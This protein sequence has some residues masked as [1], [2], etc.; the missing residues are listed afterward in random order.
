MQNAG[1]IYDPSPAD[2]RFQLE[3]LV[4]RW[5]LVA[6]YAL[7][8]QLGVIEV[9]PFWFFV[10]EGFLVTWH[11]YYT[12]YVWHE[13]TQE[14]LNAAVGYAIPFLDTV[15]VTL[16]LIAIGEPMHPIWAVY[17]FIM[18]SVA[19]FY[20]P[21]ARQYAVW[22]AV[23]YALVGLMT[24]LRGLPVP[25]AHMLVAGVILLAGLQNLAAYTGG[26]RRLRSQMSEIARIDPLTSLRNRRGLEEALDG[27]LKSASPG[28]GLALLMLDVDHFKRYNDQ[29]GHLV[30]DDILEQLGRLLVSSGRDIDIVAR[31]GG[32]EF[33]IALPDVTATDAVSIAE[34]LRQRVERSA[35]CTISIGVGVAR[36]PDTDIEELLNRADAALRVAKEAGRNRVGGPTLG[37][38]AA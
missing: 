11:V 26:E 30:A 23:N 35:L 9:T 21:V 34:R 18:V 36:G 32:D 14:P 2:G 25:S 3:V 6:L 33:V 7:F 19:H 20:Y 16:A 24:Y 15:S 22:L 29:Y 17:F 37:E 1:P 5:V 28:K 13:L 8:V 31:Y 38:R 12:W 4:L 10:S 27:A